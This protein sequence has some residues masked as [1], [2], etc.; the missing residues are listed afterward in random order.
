MANCGKWSPVEQRE[1]SRN[2]MR[3]QERLWSL[4]TEEEASL[5]R[6]E[7]LR[8]AANGYE[9][10]GS[11]REAA[12]CWA[13]QGE[14]DRAGALYARGGDLGHA[15]RL[16]L[17]A[18]YYH[19]ALEAYRQWEQQLRE[20]NLV[21][22]IQ[23]LLGQAACHMLGSRTSSSLASP[24]LSEAAGRQAYRQARNLL[25]HALESPSLSTTASC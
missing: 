19:E 8:R 10:V 18:G 1:E 23:A 7:L 21:N 4:I 15:A 6:G 17:Q 13:E 14:S 24:D 3:G 2:T 5:L 12:E 16:W 22:R 9:Q 25:M 20:A 11:W